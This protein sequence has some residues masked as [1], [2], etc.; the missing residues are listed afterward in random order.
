LARSSGL[1]AAHPSK[2]ARA[3]LAAASTSAALPAG[4]RPM[5]SPLVESNTSI[6]PFPW[7]GTHAPSM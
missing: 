5:T 2:A 4:M 6:V 7:D 3:A 1:V